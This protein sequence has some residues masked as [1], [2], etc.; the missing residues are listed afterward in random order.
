MIREAH[1]NGIKLHYREEGDPASPPLLLIHGRTADHNDWNGITQHFAAHHHVFAPDLRGH[2]GS[3]R[4]GEYPLPEMAEDIVALLDHLGIE[5][6]TLVGHSL[7]G[8]VS[9]HLAMNHPERVERLVL[10]DPAPPS[11]LEGRAPLVEDGSTGFDW[12]MMHDT[13][14]QLLNPDPAWLD[15]LG[16]ITAPTLV[17]GGGELSPFDSAA[18][19]A[20]I[21]GA[22]YV[23]IEVGHLVHVN[24]RRAFLDAVDTFLSR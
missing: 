15:G 21:P 22:E 12:R 1:V 7:G 10:E 13:E 2:G 17:I 4:P 11:P 5:R 23:T 6:A 24:A 20:R 8:A 9:Y 19:A 3:D 18:V 14:R 16:K